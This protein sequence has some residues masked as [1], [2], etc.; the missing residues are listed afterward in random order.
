MLR[1]N[2]PSNDSSPFTQLERASGGLIHLLVKQDFVNGYFWP[3]YGHI[4]L[5]QHSKIGPQFSA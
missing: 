4:S 5:V 2:I 3:F 1:S